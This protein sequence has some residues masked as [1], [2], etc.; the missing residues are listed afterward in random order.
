MRFIFKLLLAISSMSL[1]GAVY[2]VNIRGTFLGL[3]VWQSA[4]VYF[5]L[6]VIIARLPLFFIRF[7]GKDHINKISGQKP[8][9]VMYVPVYLGYFFIALSISQLDIFLCI[10]AI[11]LVFVWFSQHLYFNIMWILMGYRYYEISNDGSQYLLIT[12]RQ[13]WKAE[14]GGLLVRRINNYT[15]IEEKAL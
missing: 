3:S 15:F 1:M 12:K 9:E 6:A 10:S 14:T 5:V 13:D 7:L 8:A 11:L 2:L 4:I